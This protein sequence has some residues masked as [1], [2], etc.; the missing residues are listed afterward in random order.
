MSH[1]HL[2]IGGSVERRWQYWPVVIHS[3]QSRG[4]PES[5]DALLRMG[6]WNTMNLTA[7]DRKSG[8]AGDVLY[9]PKVGECALLAVD[10]TDTDTIAIGVLRATHHALTCTCQ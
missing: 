1:G 8:Q 9:L 7:A 3:R 5:M 6:V 10:S 4:P 2:D